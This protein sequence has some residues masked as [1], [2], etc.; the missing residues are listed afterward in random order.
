M[1][2]YKVTYTEHVIRSVDIE[3]NT[4]E[5]ARNDVQNGLIDYGESVEV[6]AELCDVTR[7]EELS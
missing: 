5:E 4:P 7:V 6:D 2:R 1:P 3:A